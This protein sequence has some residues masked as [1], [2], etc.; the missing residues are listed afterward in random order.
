MADSPPSS[1]LRFIF[2]THFCELCEHLPSPHLRSLRHHY[3]VFPAHPSKSIQEPY[4]LPPLSDFP[5]TP[6]IV[7]YSNTLPIMIPLKLQRL[8]QYGMAFQVPASPH[9]NPFLTPYQHLLDLDLNAPPLTRYPLPVSHRATHRS[10]ST[11]LAAFRILTSSYSL[12]ILPTDQSGGLVIIN[13]TELRILYSTYLQNFRTVPP[14]WYY[15]IATT[16][17]RKLHAYDQNLKA[18]VTDDRPPTFY[19]KVKVQK[20]NFPSTPTIHSNIHTMDPYAITPYIRPI[21]NHSSSISTVASQV[22]RPYFTPIIANHPMLADNL[23]SAITQ[24]SIYGPP[25]AIYHYDIVKFYPS[26]PH[27]LALEAF[28]HYFPEKRMNET[29]LRPFSPTTS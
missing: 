15:S 6:P 17:R 20:T 26:I 9:S 5:L 11:L 12:R 23:N 2:Q 28:D 1:L 22:L 24:L 25:P 14:S 16:L 10:F 29:F 27:S 13:D 18:Y 4:E 21:A 8:M 7:Y 19:F 3:E